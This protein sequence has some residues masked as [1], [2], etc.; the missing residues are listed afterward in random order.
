MGDLR[1][2]YF[3]SIT[4]MTV[5]KSLTLVKEAT[6]ALQGNMIDKER[7]GM[8]NFIIRKTVDD[9]I[10]DRLTGFDCMHCDL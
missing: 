10:D 8:M 9:V 2:C 6:W 4:L 1:S 3:I 7:N 5:N